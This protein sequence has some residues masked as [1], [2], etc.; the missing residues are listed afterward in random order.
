MS[1]PEITSDT[2]RSLKI[3]FLSGSLSRMAGGVYDATR[4]LARSLHEQSVC[5]VRAFGLSDEATSRDAS[6][7]GDVAIYSADVVGPSSFGYAPS[8]GRQLGAWMPDLIH[9]HGLWM[10]PS[11]LSSTWSARMRRPY[12]VSP[13]GMLDPW[14]INNSLWKKRLA[15]ALYEDAHL[16]RADCIH[17]LCEAEARAIRMYGLKNPICVIP[18]GI[19]L[20]VHEVQGTPDWRSRLPADAKILLYLGRLHPKKGLEELIR[21]WHKASKQSQLARDWHLVIAGWGQSAYEDELKR[22]VNALQMTGGVH[23]VGPQF[24]DDKC[25][26]Y[27]LADAFILPS[28]SEGLPMVILEAWA[29]GL[30]V[31]MTPQC[32]LPEGFA[33]EAALKIDPDAASVALGLE[34]IFALSEQD[35]GR[36]G[37][38][39][40]QLVEQR[41]NWS[42]IAEQMLDVYQWVLGYGKQPSCIQVYQ[43]FPI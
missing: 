20:P 22:V 37:F 16:R 29:Y 31:L 3:G 33:S 8:L 40:Q 23:F 34:N 27:K 32:N 5:E 35:R 25:Q 36:M 28:F 18:N 21:G 4:Y 42:S 11:I 30:P 12:I 7:W 17:A 19:N 43:S 24:G 13:H 2:S 38:R 6:G 26:T 41:F 1:C 9:T 14:A 15:A 10:F 39:G